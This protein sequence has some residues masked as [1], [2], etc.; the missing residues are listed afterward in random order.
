MTASK[1]QIRLLQENLAHRGFNPGPFDGIWG[2]HTASAMIASV[3]DRS[4]SQTKLDLLGGV[5]YRLF[6][7]H[8][9][10]L[11]VLP[12]A[13]FI[14]QAAHETMGFARFTEIW[15]PTPAQSGYEGRSDLGNTQPGDG[16]KYRGRGWFMITGRYN[17]GAYGKLLN[18][19]L[20]NNPDALIDPALS[21]KAAMFYWDSKRCITSALL[22]DTMSV[23][24]II[25]VGRR[26]TKITPNG[27]P[28]RIAKTETLLK[29]W[30]YQ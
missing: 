26:D 2:S 25:N 7:D 17:Y 9:D 22:N 23:S 1:L 28:D 24:R 5:I 14:A 20:I 4:V 21:A 6:C 29:L 8:P 15:G 12:S 16:Y 11:D 30:G 10:M 18:V 13:H 3:A 27:M 19:D